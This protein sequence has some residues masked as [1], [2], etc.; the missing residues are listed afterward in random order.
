[1]SLQFVI[2]GYNITKHPLLA[3]T[4]RR[5]KEERLALVEF[6]NANKL[7]GSPNN[8]VAIVFDGYPDSGFSGEGF[9][10]VNIIFSRRQSADEMIKAIVERLAGARNIVVVSD[11]KDIR[12]FVRSLGAKVLAVEEF[13][14][15]KDK[16]R[17]V[18]QPL[19][20]E[21]GYNQMEGINRELRRLWLGE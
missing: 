17:K 3:S 5:A 2:D 9:K 8:R 19:K 1:M 15:R 20:P 13:I 16:R 12:F 11:D 14:G 6:I 21:L 18:P 7:T 4:S 10:G